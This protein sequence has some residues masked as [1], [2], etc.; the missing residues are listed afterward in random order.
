MQEFNSK[1]NF[2]LFTRYLNH[3]TLTKFPFTQ[4]KYYSVNNPNQTEKED[5]NI[6]KEYYEIYEY[7]NSKVKYI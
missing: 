5:E 4:L 2:K 3:K 7:S 1:L 6:D